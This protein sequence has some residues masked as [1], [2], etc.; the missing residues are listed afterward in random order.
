M[1]EWLP[2][3]CLIAIPIG[4]AAYV[5]HQERMSRIRFPDEPTE[6]GPFS[7]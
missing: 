4:F 3:L 2:W 1:T 6:N 7:R 5:I